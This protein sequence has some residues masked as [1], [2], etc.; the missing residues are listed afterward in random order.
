[1]AIGNRRTDIFAA[2]TSLAVVAVFAI[3]Y[4]SGLPFLKSLD[5]WLFDRY[6]VLSPR[7]FNPDGLVRIIDIDERSLHQLG[8]WPW[9]RSFVAE[10]VERLTAAGAAAIAFDILFAEP[11]RTS[12]RRVQENWE[13]YNQRF[14]MTSGPESKAAIQLLGIDR[15]PD[16]DE[17]LAA[18][19][20][21]S[22]VILGTFLTSLETDTLPPRKAGISFQGSD[23]RAAMV[24]FGGAITNLPI[25]S[26]A[27]TGI[28]SVSLAPDGGEVVRRVPLV[29]STGGQIVP[30]LSVEALRVAQGAG[31][32][33]LKTADSS[34]EMNPSADP[35]LTS[36]RVGQ[37][38]IPLEPDGTLRVRYSG[39]KKK[40]T[41]SAYKILEGAALSPEIAR[42]VNGRII[43]V[44]TSAAG[45]R[46]LV[47]TPLDVSV[48][49][50]EVHAEII[51]QAVDQT[52]LTRPDWAPGLEILILVAGGLVVSVLIALQMSVL[53]LVYS[54]LAIAGLFYGSWR[55]FHDLELLL[56]PIAPALTVGVA[57]LTGTLHSYFTAEHS[58]REITRQFEHFV[59]PSVIEDVIS[60]PEKHLK[61]GGDRRELT[62]MFMDI[63]N[64][65]TVTETMSPEEVIAFINALLT[66]LTDVILEN[67]GTIDKYMGDAIMAFWNAP[68]FTEDMEIKAVR[69][70]LE[71]QSVLDDVNRRF[72][73]RSLPEVAIGVGINTGFCSVGNMG[74]SRRL[75]YSC[76]GD[77]V[78]LASRLEGLTKLYGIGSLIGDRTASAIKD[79]ALLETDLVTVMGRYQAERIW[80]I[81]GDAELRSTNEFQHVRKTLNAA[82]SAFLEKQWSASRK[83]FLQLSDIGQIGRT[84]LTTLADIFIRRIA[85]YEENPPPADWNGTHVATEKY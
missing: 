38:V 9:P 5:E 27:A 58:R 26:D 65:S 44:G 20:D 80:T 68:R 23:P 7:P 31:S 3:G 52:F 78:N 75:S 28:G 74:S 39:K 11:D 55:A 72:A 34:G 50:V 10:I 6:Q 43:L 61:P 15:L 64:F 37:V 48:P 69:T 8:Q 70:A 60:D 16:H 29:A 81:A 35:A 17:I 77:A 13:R 36:M 54:V 84:N 63:R 25:L 24:T 12:P 82:R 40:R 45:L 71:F 46:D 19:L 2:L 67:E 4:G 83:L 49:G 47:T 85:D 57:H 59:S 62:V 21:Q 53:G 79:F 30:A 32:Y 51:E 14:F 66:P 73:A 33:L 41:I 22:P 42:E 1:M 76:V 18:V 56:S